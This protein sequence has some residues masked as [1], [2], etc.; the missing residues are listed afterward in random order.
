MIEHYYTFIETPVFTK[1][2]DSKGSTDLLFAIQNDLLENPVRG[3]VVEGTGGVRKA[4][5][6][7]PNDNRGKSGSYRYIYLYLE[8]QGRIHLIFF[9]SKNEQS[10]LSP[11]QKRIIAAKVKELKK[12]QD[13]S[14]NKKG[15]DKSKS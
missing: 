6:A 13:E 5:I 3:D 8:L 14:S 7:D 1:Q 10:D 11:E 12:A 9:Y 2:I 4:R 15:K